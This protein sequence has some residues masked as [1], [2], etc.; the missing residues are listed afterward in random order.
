MYRGLLG[1]CFLLIINSGG[2]QS[3]ILV[4][5]GVLQ[6]TPGATPRMQKIVENV[7]ETSGE[8]L[9]LVV[10]THEHWDHISGFQHAE[11]S[12]QAHGFDELWMA[13]TGASRH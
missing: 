1:D 7:Y 9:D 11:A 13:W 3:T 6:G 2:N 10:V 4:D 12:F 8:K 5:C